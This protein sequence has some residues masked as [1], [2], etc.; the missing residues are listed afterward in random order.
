MAS[1]LLRRPLL[2]MCGRRARYWRAQ[3][4]P[5]ALPSSGWRGSLFVVAIWLALLL[6]IALAFPVRPDALIG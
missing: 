5:A 6:A 2:R 4:R 1:S 3:P